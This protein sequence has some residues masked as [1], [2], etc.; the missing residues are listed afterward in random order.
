MA[1]GTVSARFKAVESRAR[2][3]RGSFSSAESATMRRHWQLA[4]L[5]FFWDASKVQYIIT[6]DKNLAE[7]ARQ[8]PIHVF[9]CTCKL[10][11]HVRVHRHKVAFILH[12]PLEL[13]NNWLLSSRLGRASDSLVA[14]PSLFWL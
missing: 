7:T 4:L 2:M 11:V 12:S 1:K 10:Q 14:S 9:L 3:P 8:V 13:D 6:P 5:V